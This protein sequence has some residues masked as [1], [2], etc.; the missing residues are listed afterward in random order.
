MYIGCDKSI[1]PGYAM[2]MSLV[3]EILVDRVSAHVLPLIR[4][5]TVAPHKNA[6]AFSAF[7]LVSFKLT[8]NGRVHYFKQFMLTI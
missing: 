7:L 5:L 3:S 2:S 4:T 8:V 1:V 6:A